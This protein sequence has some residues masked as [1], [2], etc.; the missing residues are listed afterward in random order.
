MQMPGLSPGV[1]RNLV[2]QCRPSETHRGWDPEDPR[3]QTPLEENGGTHYR[4][5]NREGYMGIL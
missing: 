1:F 3:G 4:L 5:Q 2:E